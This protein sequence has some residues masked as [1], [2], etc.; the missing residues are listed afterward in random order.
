MTKRLELELD[1]YY[2][3]IS[4]LEDLKSAIADCV[5]EN[6][7]EFTSRT[8]VLCSQADVRASYL[9]GSLDVEHI[10]FSTPNIFDDNQEFIQNV[11]GTISVSFEYD[12]YYG[13]KDM[14]NGDLI[15]DAWG[16]ELSDEKLK[17]CLEIPEERY[18]E[19]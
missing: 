9:E 19:I 14:D 5:I 8:G 11:S 12:A 10:E 18:D 7:L 13:C 4:D 15:D 16:F 3:E 2:E 1:I 17:F 6:E